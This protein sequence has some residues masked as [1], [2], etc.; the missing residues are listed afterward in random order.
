GRP[1]GSRRPECWRNRSAGAVRRAGLHRC[2]AREWALRPAPVNAR[3]GAARTSRPVRQRRS[4]EWLA[5]PQRRSTS[6]MSTRT[7]SS[8]RAAVTVRRARAVRPDRPM[9]RPRSAAPTRTSSS[10]PRRVDFSVTRTASGSSTMPRTRWSSASARALISGLVDRRGVGV[11][12]GLALGRSLLGA[13]L[14]LSGLGLLGLLRTVAGLGGGLVGLGD[15]LLGGLLRLGGLQGAG[16][17]ALALELRPVAGDLQQR[18]DLLGRLRADAPPVLRALGVDLGDRGVLGVMVLADLLDHGPV[19]LLARI[20]D[21]DAV[22]RCTD[23]AHALQTDLD[24]HVGGLSFRDVR[25][26]PAAACGVMRALTVLGVSLPG[27]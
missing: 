22:E 19:A 21:H 18:G 1:P 11:L 27:G 16:G 25:V 20:G 12:G 17:V 23:L 6:T 14:D 5:A 26:S 15:E 3:S 4:S 13:G 8:D 9:T 24:S 7:S 10:G 2:A